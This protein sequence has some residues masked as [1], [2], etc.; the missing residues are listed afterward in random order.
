[1]S[2]N[3]ADLEARACS[4]WPGRI[5]RRPERSYG[6]DPGSRHDWRP[7]SACAPELPAA[8]ETDGQAHATVS[9][10]GP[11]IT[12]S[13][14]AASYPLVDAR[15]RTGRIRV[16]AEES[17]RKSQPSP[18]HCSGA[19]AIFMLKFARYLA[20]HPPCRHWRGAGAYGCSNGRATV[21]FPVAPILEQH[22]A[23]GRASRPVARH[24]NQAH[25]PARDRSVDRGPF[26]GGGEPSQTR[27]HDDRNRYGQ[28]Q[29]QPSQPRDRRRGQ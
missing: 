14:D 13:H 16:S 27:E 21:S 17:L 4:A 1:M 15:R 10:P 20:A 5:G 6:F 7:P 19:R 9:P 3:C 24:H 8:F 12:R 22:A 11:T 28:R 29:H 18:A 2:S 26:P 23:C 25:D